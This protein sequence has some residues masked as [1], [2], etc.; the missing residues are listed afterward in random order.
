MNFSVL[1]Y[2]TLFNK[3]FLQLKTI[4]D[5]SHP[6]ILCLQEVDIS[7]NNLKS[8]DRF[9]YKLADYSGTFIKFG[10]AF[11]VATYFNPKKFK[12]VNSDSPKIGSNLLEYLFMI[13]QL[14]LRINKP[15]TVLRTDF[16]SKVGNK[17]ITICNSH[18][19]VAAPNSV[20]VFHINKAL[21]SLD[22]KSTI[23]LIITGDFNYVPYQRKQLDN[24][25]KKYFMMEATKNIRQTVE[26]SPHGKKEDFSFLQGF[27]ARNINHFF[28]NQMKYDYIYYRGVKLN[29]TDRI[30]VRFSDH[31]PII[32]S[33]SL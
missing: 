5:Q 20:R 3:A 15:K 25:M 19:I 13:P 1:T 8:L 28:G 27:I 17:K 22:I 2:N 16:I 30:E 24:I 9:G 32:S 4:I 26:F 31:Y 6:D 29:K 11:G 14:I 21:D 33:F 23:P 18:L 7:A 10:K 12:F